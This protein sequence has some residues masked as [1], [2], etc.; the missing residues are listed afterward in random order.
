MQRRRTAFSCS[1]LVAIGASGPAAAVDTLPL[2]S[3]VGTSSR[4]ETSGSIGFEDCWYGAEL[5][6]CSGPP[7]P[8]PPVSVAAD[9][10]HSAETADTN[11]LSLTDSYTQDGHLIEASASA[12]TAFGVN[13]ASVSATG[14]YVFDT[15]RRVPACGGACEENVI[16]V[17]EGYEAAAA[18]SVWQ[19]TW[20]FHGPA[21]FVATVVIRIEGTTDLQKPNLGYIFDGYYN[22]K[23]GATERTQQITTAALLVT[24]AHWFANDYNAGLPP[25]YY[26]YSLTNGWVDHDTTTYPGP[27]FSRELRTLMYVTHDYPIHVGSLLITDAG[28]A[29]DA[30]DALDVS[31]TVTL[32]R[33]EVPAGVT[34]TAASGDASIYHVPEPAAEALELAAAGALLAL[35][36]RCAGGSSARSRRA[37]AGPARPA[38]PP[39]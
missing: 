25:G 16:D 35:S 4:V 26:V 9:H 38:A 32:E 12:E 24:G 20:T 37:A 19:D 36:R 3:L 2:V 33:I 14:S 29:L 8:A 10:D 5:T 23:S 18:V 39:R 17:F 31:H 30:D 15:S 1:A 21:D 13:R 7:P 34:M 27:S 11:S 22:D 28:G 6:N